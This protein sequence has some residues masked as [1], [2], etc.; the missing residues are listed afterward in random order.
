MRSL[1]KLLVI[2]LIIVYPFVVF[3]SLEWFSI[4]YLSLLIVFIFFLRLL[5]IKSFKK[6]NIT[7]IILTL[8]GM[9]LAFIGMISN[10]VIFIQ[11]Y[12]VLVSLSLLGVFTFSLFQPYSFITHI[13]MQIS[14]EPLPSYVVKYTRKVTLVW[15]IFFGFNATISIITILTGS[16][17]L[18]TLYNGLLSYMLIGIL[19]SGEWIL[20]WYVKR[21]YEQK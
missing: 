19:I 3:F 9:F 2:T 5:T 16:I 17:T 15:C 11:L 1:I 4:R 13:A 6:N 7:W 18:W 14:K 10:N 8:L 12:P 20:R 21:S